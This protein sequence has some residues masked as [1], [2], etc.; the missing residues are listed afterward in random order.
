MRAL[1]CGGLLL[2]LCACSGGLELE[3][4]NAFPC[5]FESGVAER[6]EGCPA[7][8]VCGLEDRCQ[9]EAPETFAPGAVPDYAGAA[10]VAPGALDAKVALLAGEPRLRVWLADE[11]DAA[12]P[13]LVTGV[14]ATPLPGEVPLLRAAGF[15]L[16]PPPEGGP[17]IALVPMGRGLALVGVLP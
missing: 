5:D 12:A 11:E 6:D 2:L 8:W 1:R 15:F 16:M 7:G 17:R 10:R 14:S 9:P 13:L 3:Q 4:G